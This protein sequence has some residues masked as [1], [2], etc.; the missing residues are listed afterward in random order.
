MSVS[1]QLVCGRGISLNN[2]AIL[3][4][5]SLGIC[6]ENVINVSNKSNEFN[7]DWVLLLMFKN[8]SNAL[9]KETTHL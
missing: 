5:S 9:E 2:T 6:F 8:T 1:C 7:T 4:Y 3:F